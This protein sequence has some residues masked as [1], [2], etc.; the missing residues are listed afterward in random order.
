[1]TLRQAATAE[2]EPTNSYL[3]VGG[4]RLHYLDWGGD[5]ANRTFLLLHGGSAHAHWWDTVAP[6]LVPCGRVLALDFRGHGRSAWV[7]PPNYGFRIYVDDVRK[8][9]EHLG[10]R[11]ILIGHSMGGE[12]AQWTAALH[13][14]LLDALVCVDSPFG[15]PPLLRRLMWRWR[16]KKFK[17]TR[18]ELKSLDAIQRK[19]RLSPPGTHLSRE[20]LERLAL[21]GAEQLPNGNWAFRVDP[22][23]RNWRKMN[24]QMRRRPNLTAIRLPTL[25]LRGEQS[26]LVTHRNA[27]RMNAKIRGSVHREI[28]RAF[29]HVPLDNPDDTAS[30]IIEFIDSL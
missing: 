9:I 27:R 19:F 20:D 7:R 26:G 22:E 8:M 13:P 11:V 4:I 16:R 12:V 21:L 24:R 3:T 6:Q 17:G 15:G 1:M 25:I 2:A 29:H 23:T 10:C 14:E 30:A 18:P 5:P 28:P